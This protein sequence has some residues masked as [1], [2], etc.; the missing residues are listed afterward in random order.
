MKLVGA[1]TVASG[2]VN[3]DAM[4][5]LG[6]AGDI[7]AA[8][9]LDGVTGINDM[10]LPGIANDAAWFVGRIDHHL[11]ELLPSGAGAQAFASALV[12]RLVHDVDIARDGSSLP[13]TYDPP[14]ACLMLIRKVK[15]GVE[16]I[17]LGDSCLLA[18][19]R[20]GALTR[21]VDFPNNTFDDWFAAESHRLRLS[22]MTAA[23]DIRRALSAALF[24]NRRRRNR[25]GGY[26]VLEADRACL[27]F[28]EVRQITDIDGI[29]LATDGF[30]RLA[31]CYQELSETELL[32]KSIQPGGVDALMSRLRAIE[33]AD[34]ICMTYPRHKPRDDA[35]AVA[36]RL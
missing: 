2:T 5:Y 3:E 22:G 17:R 18:R 13:A 23:A 15:D 11:R 19:G 33:A 27:N 20:N 10:T 36:L 34:E 30:F 32:N 16:A 6:G 29:L 14:A 9:V 31:D 35:T 12:D 1:A 25:T 24:E 7:E 21:M 28:L 4:G 26:G 8:W